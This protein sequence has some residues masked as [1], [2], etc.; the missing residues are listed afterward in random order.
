MKQKALLRNPLVMVLILTFLSFPFMFSGAMVSADNSKISSSLTQAIQSTQDNDMISCYLWI[1]D[2]DIESIILKSLKQSNIT[3]YNLLNDNITLEGIQNYIMEKRKLTS[4]AYYEH[5]MNFL[6]DYSE[7]IQYISRYSPMIILKLTK[8]NISELEHNFNVN[9]IDLCTEAKCEP[10]SY[11]SIPT[12]KANYVRDTLGYDGQ[13]VKIGL[14][15]AQSFPYENYPQLLP[16]SPSSTATNKMVYHR[17]G[18]GTA[19]DIHPTNIAQIIVGQPNMQNGINYKGIVPNAKLYCAY[20]GTFSTLDF[21][22]ETECLLDYG[23]N[24]INMSFGLS[25]SSAQ[26]GNAEKWYDHIAMN[27]DVHIVKSAGN[28]EYTHYITS[29]GMAYNI[30]TVGASDDNDTYTNYDDDTIWINSSYSE[31]SGLAYKPDLVAPGT[32]IVF[33]NDTGF[34]G[35]PYIGSGTSYAAPHVVGVMAQLIQKNPNLAIK[36]A[37]MKAIITAGLS[38]TTFSNSTTLETIYAPALYE[39]HGAGLLNA[40]ESYNVVNSSASYTGHLYADNETYTRTLFASATRVRVSLTWL[41]R[42]IFSSGS[43]HETGTPDIQTPLTNLDLYIKSSGT[44]IA[45]SRS[46]SNNLEIVDIY[47]PGST[48]LTIEVKREGNPPPSY[49]TFAL[50]WSLQ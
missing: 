31:N 23:V 13:G 5:N 41:K 42:N 20:V 32:D 6:E 29:P 25:E 49:D 38:K 40:Q 2:I 8:N 1:K 11:L 14:L 9:F 24:I 43:G 34:S 48:T 16:I 44:I 46:S 21:Y 28:E 33:S 39:K 47:V 26:Y 50:A 19:R 10:E 7:N 36:Q 15:E 17:C 4:Q 18:G 37:E 3:N 22:R 12:I 27:H 35:I 30:V 45:S